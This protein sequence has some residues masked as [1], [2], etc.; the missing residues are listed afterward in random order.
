LI[1]G[2]AGIDKSALVDAFGASLDDAVVLRVE[3]DA[4]PAPGAFLDQVRHAVGAGP[5][6]SPE[7]ALTLLLEALGAQQDRGPVLLVLHDLQDIDEASAVVLA[8]LLRRLH[9][10][11]VLVVATH[12]DMPGPASVS[13]R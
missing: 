3:A 8:R 4:D 12:R 13:A 6:T 5:A 1:T 10:D 7:A 9:H 11:R 2:P